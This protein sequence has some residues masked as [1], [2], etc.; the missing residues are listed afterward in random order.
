MKDATGYSIIPAVT[1]GMQ[2]NAFN[3]NNATPTQFGIT[4]DGTNHNAVVTA[5]QTQPPLT[6]AIKTYDNGGYRTP[7]YSGNK[8][9][10]FSSTTSDGTDM[11]TAPNT[12][13]IAQAIDNLIAPPNNNINFAKPRRINHVAQ[14]LQLLAIFVNLLI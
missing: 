2:A 3:A 13:Y 12:T 14:N 11:K 9:L 8:S 7:V 6:I 1:P 5:G 4:T 10:I